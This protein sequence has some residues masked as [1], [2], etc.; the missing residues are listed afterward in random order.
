MLG[1]WS[2]M[3]QT[4]ATWTGVAKHLECMHTK[5]F[6]V[7]ESSEMYTI[8]TVMETCATSMFSE[9]ITLPIPTDRQTSM[10]LNL[11]ILLLTKYY[12][13][14]IFYKGFLIKG[15]GMDNIPDNSTQKMEL[16]HN[17]FPLSKI[18]TFTTCNGIVKF[19]ISKQR[20]IYSIFY[21]CPKF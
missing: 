8:L 3:R 4:S 21:P 9:L 13:N 20:K 5:L 2:S 17:S 14:K 1:L 15:L 18:F 19:T 12:F 6:L 7:L 10:L 11:L 16:F